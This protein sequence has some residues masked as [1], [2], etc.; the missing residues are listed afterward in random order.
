MYLIKWV[1]S[2]SLINTA[3]IPAA[4]W[5]L[6]LFTIHDIYCDIQ[7]FHWPHS[8]LLFQDS[9]GSHQRRGISKDHNVF[10][11]NNTIILPLW[12]KVRNYF[13]YYMLGY[14]SQI[15]LFR[16]VVINL[17]RELTPGRNHTS[18]S[19]GLQRLKYF[20]FTW[21]LPILNIS[22]G[23]NWLSWTLITNYL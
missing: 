17:L 10:P 4:G 1:I 18:R 11:L 16:T 22:F 12:L 6:D 2:W 9:S 14:A 23:K 3:T 7:I 21:S 20:P 13:C 19:Q 15:A 8:V 5:Y